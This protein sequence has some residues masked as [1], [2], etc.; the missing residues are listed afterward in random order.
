MYISTYV[1]HSIVAADMCSDAPSQQLYDAAM[2]IYLAALIYVR[3][4]T[5]YCTISYFVA[6]LIYT[7]IYRREYPQCVS[8]THLDYTSSFSF[9][10]A[11]IRSSSA[12]CL[13][14]ATVDRID[15]GILCIID[16]E[17]DKYI[18]RWK[19]TVCRRQLHRYICHD[20]FRLGGAR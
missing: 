6:G 17:A 15:A 4:G 5:T 13:I 2:L 19:S 10:A 7:Y 3:S 14:R 9:T 20:C 12:R 8:H 16:V 18:Y 1:L 11:S